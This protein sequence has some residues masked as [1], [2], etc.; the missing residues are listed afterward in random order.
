[1]INKSN[2]LITGG[3]GSFGK[4][5]VKNLLMKKHSGKIAIFS[6]DEFKQ[7]QFK[8]AISAYDKK[9]LLRYY[10]GDIRDAGRLDYALKDID[11]VIHA[12]AMKQ[13]DTCEYNPTEAIKTNIIGSQN[14][15]NS[16]INNSVK[17]VVALSTDKAASPSTLYGA[18]KL[19][20]DKLF[21]SANN[22]VGKKNINF[23]VVR[24]GNVM[25]SRGSIIPK[26]IDL[27]KQKKAF[28]VTN[29]KMTRFN[30]TLQDSI[31]FVLKVLNFRKDVYGIFVPV[32]PSYDMMTLVRS[33]GGPNYPLKIIGIRESEKLHEE[34][35][36]K[37]DIPLTIKSK[38]FY[39]ICKSYKDYNEYLKI[40]NF[41]K[42]TL[43]GS[44]NSDDNTK[45]DIKNLKNLII[46]LSKNDI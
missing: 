4:N 37:H 2:I 8:S 22:Y 20:A 41:K 34:L 16:A 33:I 15:I 27:K 24:Y 45:M 26:F 42:C 29:E 40:K 14:L 38:N 36:S 10:V 21:L 6:R 9:N 35:I 7:F 43:P 30:I 23:S 32:I 44:Y 18:T 25:G 31:D 12:A 39:I 13:I 46:N 11:V 1:M 5:F 28:T 3:T 19:C 17:K